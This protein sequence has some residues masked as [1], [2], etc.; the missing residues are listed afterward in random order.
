MS[1][2]GRKYYV[3]VAILT[4]PSKWQNISGISMDLIKQ[5]GWKNCK[6]VMNSS[7]LIKSLTIWRCGVMFNNAA[8]IIQKNWREYYL[9]NKV[10]PY[11]HRFKLDNCPLTRKKLLSDMDKVRLEI[12]ASRQF[13]PAL[14]AKLN[15]LIRMYL[16]EDYDRFMTKRKKLWSEVKMVLNQEL[17]ARSNGENW[18]PVTP[19]N[20]T[21]KQKKWCHS[22]HCYSGFY[23]SSVDL[24]ESNA[25][26]ARL[27][28]LKRNNAACVI[29]RM[30]LSRFNPE[31]QV[32]EYDSDYSDYST[33]SNIEAAKEAAKHYDL[34][35]ELYEYELREMREE[36]IEE[37]ERQQMRIDGWVDDMCNPYNN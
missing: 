1:L 29:Q 34:D 36:E 5:W 37:L 9:L 31:D 2:F 16:A 4:L 13:K 35:L 14:H 30:W 17:I 6:E 24:A 8:R 27:N 28:A 26:I 19:I 22:A 12:S 32:K 3:Q 11:M 7:D 10:K 25:E 21:E 20:L 33:E 23:Y 18:V 15:R